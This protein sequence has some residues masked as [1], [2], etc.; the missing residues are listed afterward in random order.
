M[1]KCFRYV[2]TKTVCVYFKRA[3]KGRFSVVVLNGYLYEETLVCWRW[4]YT[5]IHT[6]THTHTHT[7]LHSHT[8]RHTDTRCTGVRLVDITPNIGTLCYINTYLVLPILR[9]QYSTTI[10]YTVTPLWIALISTFSSHISDPCLRR[11]SFYTIWR[12]GRAVCV[13]VCV[14]T[15][16]R[17][18]SPVCRRD[19]LLSENRSLD[20]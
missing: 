15:R 14:C 1:L 13:C 16:L 2:N 12:T 19:A 5:H 10:Q 6:R 9:L 3:R 11:R 17:E 20:Q 7:H 8:D 4:S 18:A